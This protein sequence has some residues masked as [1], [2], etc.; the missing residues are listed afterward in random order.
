MQSI[1]LM[2]SGEQ[3]TSAAEDSQV[4]SQKQAYQMTSQNEEFLLQEN[5]KLREVL[6]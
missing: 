5:G 3:F 4:L 6:G 1:E 2:S